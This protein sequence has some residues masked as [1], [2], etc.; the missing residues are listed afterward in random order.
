MTEANISIEQLT[1]HLKVAHISGQLDESNIDD[2]IQA[3]YKTL[4]DTPIHLGL[5]FELSELDYMNSKSIGYMTDI[6][7][8]V[9]ENGGKVAIA[10]AKPNIADILEVVGLTQLINIYDSLEL[11]KMKVSEA[12][13]KEAEQTKVQETIAAAPAEP[14]QAVQPQAETQAPAQ[15]TQ[16]VAPVQPQAT[17]EEIQI[18]PAPVEAVTPA[19]PV[20]PVQTTPATPEP[21]A[22]PQNTQAVPVSQFEQEPL[23]NQVNKIQL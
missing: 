11:A 3:V 7:G 5:I 15:A 2:K 19:Q 22:T 21:T 1:P 4:E 14:T 12:I 10:S 16:P 8:K 20:A 6:Y 23:N 9:T 17:M 18:T 13:P